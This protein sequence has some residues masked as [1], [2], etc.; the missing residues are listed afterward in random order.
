MAEL[1]QDL[2]EYLGTELVRNLLES[3]LVLVLGLLLAAAARLAVRRLSAGR[4]SVQAALLTGRV[5][6]YGILA[7]V[8]IQVLGKFNVDLSLLLGA[9]GVL[10]VAVGFAAQ[11]ATSN[12]ISGLFLIGER[13]FAIGDV[14]R[15]GST[16]GE[17][18]S[19]DLLS[20]KLRTFDNLLVRL[21]NETLLKSEIINLTAFPIRRADLMIGVAYKE[22]LGRVREVLME[23]ADRNPLCLDEPKPLFQILGFGES[24]ID[25]QFSVWGTRQ[26]YLELKTAM[27]MEIKAAFDAAGIEI[28]FP[29]RT[30]YS[31]SATDPL[32]VRVTGA[33]DGGSAG[34]PGSA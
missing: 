7:I 4:L 33:S 6:Y 9:A 2:R 11:T 14:V 19:I 8:A 31:G 22:N 27:Q 21:P 3:F 23:V 34:R 10:T 30:L 25:L 5:V 20:V 28:P 1:W 32:P 16:T 12:L 17:V 13:P 29:H 24:S 18:L 15:V 26:S